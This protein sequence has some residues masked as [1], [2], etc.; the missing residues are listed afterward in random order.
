MSKCAGSSEGGTGGGFSLPTYPDW[1]TKEER[2]E[3][4]VQPRTSSTIQL[5]EGWRNPL[6]TFC[7]LLTRDL[8][9]LGVWQDWFDRLDALEF[10]YKVIAHCSECQQN[11]S[12][13]QCLQHIKSDWL[14]KYII[15]VH[16]ETSWGHVMNAQL[17]LYRE[18][19]SHGSAWITLHSESCVPFVSADAFV[20]AFE[21]NQHHSLINVR[22]LPQRLVDDNVS[23]LQ[24]IRKEHRAKHD[25]WCVLSRDHLDAVL[26]FADVSNRSD[27]AGMLAQAIAD[28]HFTGVALRTLGLLDGPG[29]KQVMSTFVDWSNE[30]ASGPRTYSAW[31]TE[32]QE[33]VQAI[34]KSRETRLLTVQGISTPL[35]FRKVS[36]SFP[37]Q[38]V[39]SWCLPCE[40]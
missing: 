37:T 31:D 23:N 30:D 21:E 14:R 6:V 17:A 5:A 24:K 10:R 18:A 40:E 11:C 26:N 20:K 13:Q 8:V 9:K 36:E 34:L 12:G 19:R 27:A 35:F 2:T 33:T 22:N 29:V 38:G 32:A 28:E 3:V 15:P 4:T 16:W 25:Q 1:G 7:F 39:V